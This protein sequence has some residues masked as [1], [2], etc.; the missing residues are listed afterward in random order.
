MFGLPVITTYGSVPYP[1]EVVGTD[2]WD[3]TS[4]ATYARGSVGS[5]FH[6]IVADIEP[7]SVAGDSVFVFRA[8]AT[9]DTPQGL[10]FV[11][12]LYPRGWRSGDPG[13]PSLNFTAGPSGVYVTVPVA[14]GT[15]QDIEVSIVDWLTLAPA[16]PAQIVAYF[17]AGGTLL[18]QPTGLLGGTGSVTI[19]RISILGTE[20]DTAV[21]YRR[22]FPRSDGLA[23][24]GAR[25]FPR[26]RS[27][28]GSNRTSGAYL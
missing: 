23:G 10:R 13:E 15:P 14:D 21:P 22:N 20:A 1:G 28:Q 19:H 9:L 26:P 8:S 5:G 25:T 6:H 27:I 4:D 11:A 17:A 18:I 2:P 3:D 7:S 24:G 12:N 16:T